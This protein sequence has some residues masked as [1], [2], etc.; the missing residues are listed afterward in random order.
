MSKSFAIDSSSRLAIELSTAQAI[1]ET[2][3]TPRA[4]TVS[5]LISNNEFSQLVDLEVDANNYLDSSSFADDY[6]VTALLQKSANLPL[7]V[8]RKQVAIDAFY[9][10]ESSCKKTNDRFC[11]MPMGRLSGDLQLVRDRIARIL[12]PLDTSTLN[13]I[14]DRCRFGPGATTGVR[15]MGSVMSDKYDAEMHL[16]HELIPFYRALLGDNW[17]SIQ[18]SPIIVKGNKFTTVPK[19]AKTD[20]G[21]CI[22]PTLNIYGQLGIG[23]CIRKRLKSFGIDLNSQDKNRSLAKR[24][25]SDYLATIDLSAASDSL[26]WGVV[27]SLLPEDWFELLNLFRSSHTYLGDNLIELEKFSSM[28]NG[29]TFELESLIFAAVTSVCV[30]Y[31]DSALWS[32]YGDDIICPQKYSQRVIDNLNHLGFTVNSKKSFLAGSFFES[33]GTDWFCGQ[34]VRPFY[35]KQRKDVLIPY[36][37]QIVN[38]IRLYASRICSDSFCDARFHAVWKSVYKQIPN[39]WKQCKVPSFF[40]DVGIISSFEEAA[41]PKAKKGWEGYTVRHIM[42]KPVEVRKRT[43]G[44]L[45]AA[46]ACPAPEISTRGREPKRGYLRRPVPKLTVVSQWSEGFDWL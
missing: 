19:N 41:P 22:E 33:C 29:Y 26:S 35:L 17:W 36:C 32:V 11:A 14:Q 46:L 38:G 39:M 20:R 5:L 30:P 3:D 7:E 9:A 18:A 27:L 13:F 15:G 4:L 1:C 37:V 40:G 6:L 25:Y 12:G 23:A 10:S 24:A 16:T 44:R 28:G 2:I 42:C 31:K 8:D 34:P 43:L 45:L 21:I